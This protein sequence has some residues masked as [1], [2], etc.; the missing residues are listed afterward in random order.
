MTSISGA[1]KVL[2]FDETDEGWFKYS[3]KVRSIVS[4]FWLFWI[5]QIASSNNVIVR[6][7]GKEGFAEWVLEQEELEQEL[8]ARETSADTAADETGGK[9]KSGSVA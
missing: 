7:K 3:K 6:E 5:L 1:D 8:C 2:V 4:S 9:S